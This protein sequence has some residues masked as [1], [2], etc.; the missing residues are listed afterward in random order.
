MACH[1]S[2]WSSTAA[3]NG[4]R[5][6]AARPCVGAPPW[7]SGR[8]ASP[9][10]S[11]FPR[12]HCAKSSRSSCTTTRPAGPTA[13][14]SGMVRPAEPMPDSR[15]RPP[16]PTP[17]SKRMRLA[18]LGRMTCALRAS[19]AARSASVGRSR[20]TGLPAT[21]RREPHGRPTHLPGSRTPRPLCL[22]APPP[23]HA[24]RWRKP[25]A[26]SK[27]TTRS[28]ARIAGSAVGSPDWVGGCSVIRQSPV[29][30]CSSGQGALELGL[31]RLE[32]LAQ[33]RLLL[34]QARDADLQRLLVL[35]EAR[36]GG[37]LAGLLD[38][39]G[40]DVAV[41]RSV[42]G[43]GLEGGDG[44]IAFGLHRL[45]LR[46]L[47]LRRLELGA[48]GLQLRQLLL[49][50]G[51]EGRLGH[52]AATRVP[53]FKVAQARPAARIPTPPRGAHAIRF[54]WPLPYRRRPSG[55][56][57]RAILD[58]AARMSRI[59]VEGVRKEMG[60]RQVLEGVDLHAAS[61]DIVALIGPSG[62]GK[63]TL[64]RT[65][66]GEVRPDAGR[67][68]IDGMDVTRMRVEKRRVA[69]VRS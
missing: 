23:S 52:A 61:G 40:A 43:Q 67:I 8:S 3:W 11:T 65:I 45:E 20:T 2:G 25:V 69:I 41:H 6:P 28:P 12:P 31:E 68:I 24:S 4:P 9:A 5:T 33:R 18:S 48:L 66:L 35:L 1:G 42:V 51:G 44:L 39:E 63:T 7:P 54:L 13:Q 37:G 32:G 14:H 29:E 53:L 17:S 60:G 56:R 46:A 62:C 26:A 49:H 16:G 58:G 55:E 21:S 10:F 57:L 38:E 64:L 27:T 22:R 15:T 50:G 47:L 30:S 19:V 34:L 36:Q 59:H